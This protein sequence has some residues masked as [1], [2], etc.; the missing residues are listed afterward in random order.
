MVASSMK[1]FQYRSCVLCGKRRV[2]PNNRNPLCYPED[3][4]CRACTRLSDFEEQMKRYK[5]HT[6]LRYLNTTSS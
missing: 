6:G 4:A 2:G 3:G 5:E 1:N